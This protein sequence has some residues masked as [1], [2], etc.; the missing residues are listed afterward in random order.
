MAAELGHLARAAAAI[1]CLLTSHVAGSDS[2]AQARIS[3]GTRTCISRERDA[4]L[5]FKADLVD[6]AGHLSSWHGEDCCRWEGVRCS[7]RTGHVVKLNLCNTY[8]PYFSAHIDHSLSL[9]RDEMSSSL[10]ALQHLRYLDL[11]GNEFNGT[12]IHVFVG[13]LE[14]LSRK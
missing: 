14:N 12:S 5:S 1:L 4:L 8:M 9:S 11:S 7:N 6:P 2:H 10:A 3:G 13:F